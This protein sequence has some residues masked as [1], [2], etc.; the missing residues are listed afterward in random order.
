MG[1]LWDR[2]K[3]FFFPKFSE[4]SLF[5]MGVAFILVFSSTESLISRLYAFHVR[6]L[7]LGSVIIATLGVVFIV[8]LGLCLYFVLSEWE[9]SRFEKYTMLCFAILSNAFCGIY[10]SMYIMNKSAGASGIF[11]IVPI[12]NIINCVL[13]LGAFSEKNI[14]DEKATILEVFFG[15][16][17]IVGIFGICRFVFEIYWALTFSIC[18]IFATGF[19]DA[20]DAIFHPHRCQAVEEDDAFEGY[21][22]EGHKFKRCVFCKRLIRPTETSCIIER[23]LIVCEECHDKI[24]GID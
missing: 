8:G 14:S 5:M 10:T 23:K 6:H 18:V 2:I 9:K 13:M 22:Q 3:G 7:E 17:I 20:S 12:W 24:Q 1:I 19:S 11:F 21:L 4:L 16:I 15:L